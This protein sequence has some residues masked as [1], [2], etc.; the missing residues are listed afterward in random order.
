MFHSH[1]RLTF[2]FGVSCPGVAGFTTHIFWTQVTKDLDKYYLRP[3]QKGCVRCPVLHTKQPGRKGLP[4]QFSPGLQ[5]MSH[6][7]SPL[8]VIFCVLLD[9]HSDF[10]DIKEKRRTKLNFLRNLWTQMIIFSDHF[11]SGFYGSTTSQ[12]FL[13]DFHF[14]LFFSA[15]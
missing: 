13:S 2:P 5:Q 15:Q 8:I 10:G 14:W 9:P 6:V 12:H 11:C 1:L 7:F 3:A 4:L